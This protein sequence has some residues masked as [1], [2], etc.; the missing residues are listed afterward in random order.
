MFG[1]IYLTT[2]L[3]NQKQ[4]IGRRK[5]DFDKNYLGSGTHLCR[6]VRKYGKDK[7]SVEALFFAFDNDLLDL[8]EIQFIKEYDAVKS[9]LFYNIAAG[10]NTRYGDIISTETKQKMSK[11]Q[12][13]IPKPGNIGKIPW[14]KGRKDPAT[15]KRMKLNNPMKD[16]AIAK[17]AHDKLKGRPSPF[18]MPIIAKICE[19]CGNTFKVSSKKSTNRRFCDSSCA[20]TF[21]NLRR[22]KKSASGQFTGIS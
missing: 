18:K 15:A 11:S 21:S 20:A 13:G 4:Y 3:V 10:G 1:Y 16:P 5:G 22:G 9:P 6:S 17:K 12:K 19:I 14:N 8:S 7:F 2:N